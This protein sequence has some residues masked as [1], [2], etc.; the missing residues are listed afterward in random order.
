MGLNFGGCVWFE[1]NRTP[2]VQWYL[3]FLTRYPKLSH[4][5]MQLNIFHFQSWYTK[6]ISRPFQAKHTI[7]L[8][9]LP[10]PVD[11]SSLAVHCPE[12]QRFGEIWFFFFFCLWEQQEDNT[13]NM[14]GCYMNNQTP[15]RLTYQFCRD[16]HKTYK[17]S[18][19]YHRWYFVLFKN[20]LLLLNSL[21][22]ICSVL[23]SNR[24]FNSNGTARFDQ[25]VLHMPN[26]SYNQKPAGSSHFTWYYNLI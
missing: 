13:S 16:V 26:S 22:L 18:V 4:R 12:V 25:L 6:S 3:L 23:G 11:R 5:G 20:S 24:W 2:Q 7:W 10:S 14:A 8:S 1:L 19:L 17:T 9:W 21:D 15:L